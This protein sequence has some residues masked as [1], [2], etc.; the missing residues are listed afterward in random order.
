MT[1]LWPDMLWGL[2][3][4]PLLVL[5]YLWLLRRRK[6]TALRYASLALVKEALGARSAW[7]RHVPPALLLA[8]LGA[9][10][11]A[12]A[13]PAAIITLPSHGETIVLVMDVS[14]SMR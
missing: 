12:M 3:A 14:G 8:A 1:F 11:L 7:R 2:V 6:K 10:L 9:L 13:R 5:L 4:L